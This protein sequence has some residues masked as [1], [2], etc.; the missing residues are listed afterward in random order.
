MATRDRPDFLPIALEGYR[1]Q[2]YPHRELIVI[3]HGERFPADA[4]VVGTAG[5]RIVR[6]DPTR[7]YGE[8]L[9]AGVEHATG[10][11]VCNV[12]DD[13]WYGPDFLTQCV[14]R[15]VEEWTEATSS[16]LLLPNA[17]LIFDVAAWE[18]RTAIPGQTVGSGIWFLRDDAIVTPFRPLAIGPDRT[19]AFDLWV[20]GVPRVR[21]EQP[22]SFVVVRHGG[23]GANRGHTWN[24]WIDGR[25]VEEGLTALPL[26]HKRPEELIEPWALPFYREL[27][28]QLA[29]SPTG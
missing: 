15:I 19:F 3:D 6:F 18:I 20:R 13:D 1:R 7:S 27:H 9:N 5:G 28:E 24:R 17:F 21:I 25:T 10:L 14:A 23:P 2:R 12:D 16:L 4:K 29:G 22:E 8:A 11:L 26:Y